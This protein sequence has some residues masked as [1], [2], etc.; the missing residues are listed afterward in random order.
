MARYRKRPVVIDAVQFHVGQDLPEPFQIVNYGYPV[1]EN[2]SHP[3]EGKYWVQTL[4]GP[5]M[6]RDGDWLVRGTKGEFYPVKPD[7]FVDIYE[8]V[9]GGV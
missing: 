3:L 6:V 5:L 1:G 4:E 2:E 8:L 7:I 9:D